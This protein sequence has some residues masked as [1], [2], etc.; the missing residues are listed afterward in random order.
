M[1]EVYLTHAR[2]LEIAEENTQKEYYGFSF[3]RA[4]EHLHQWCSEN[5]QYFYIG[6]RGYQDGV[7]GFVFKFATRN[8]AVLFK[9]RWA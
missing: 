1:K 8:D 5:C 3:D 6:Q 2:F 4:L 7:L 9:L